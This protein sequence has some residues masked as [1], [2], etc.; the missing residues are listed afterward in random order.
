MQRELVEILACPV[1]GQ[2]LE[3]EVHAE[4]DGE[5]VSGTL[6]T[7]DGRAFPIVRGIPRMNVDMDALRNVARSFG[8][9][10]KA[11]HR[12]RFES[13]TLFG[14]TYQE[15]WRLWLRAMGVDSGDVR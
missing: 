2:E 8:Y 6:T 9:E 14:R 3:L 4:K 5:I 12:G 15:D 11:H 7:A 10:W 1:T 13:D